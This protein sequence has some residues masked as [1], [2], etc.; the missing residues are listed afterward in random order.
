VNVP[1]RVAIRDGVGVESPVFTTRTPAVVLRGDDE[2]QEPSERRAVP[3]II[4]VSNSAFA[5]ASLSGA[6]RWGRKD[7]GG[8]GVVLVSCTVLW[9]TSRGTPEVRVTSG[10]SAKRASAGVALPMFFTLRSRVDAVWAGA[11]NEVIPYK[12][13]L[14]QQSTKRQKVVSRSTPMIGSWMPAP[15]NSR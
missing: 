13:L 10:F 2:D 4:I 9:H 12:I 6:R 14:L 1:K 11:D 7:T 15:R 3:S 5:I 8:P